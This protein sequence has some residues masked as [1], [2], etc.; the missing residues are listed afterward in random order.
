MSSD[1]P[2]RVF[3]SYSH[4]SPDHA[5]SMLRLADQLR[6]DGV[7]AWIDQYETSPSR[8]WPQWMEEQ[9][10]RADFVLCVC[11]E[12]YRRRFEQ[13]EDPGR[14][15]GVTWEGS[16]LRIRLY[17][18]QGE[19]RKIRPLL[20]DAQDEEHIPLLL[21]P[22]TYFRPLTSSG[23]ESLLRYLTDQPDTAAPPLGQRKSLLTRRRRSL[24]GNTAVPS[25]SPNE[26]VSS[27]DV[28]SL[29]RY[30]AWAEVHYSHLDLIG[31]NAGDVQ[32]KL[33]DVYVPLRVHHRGTL[34]A[35]ALAFSHGLQGAGEG[36][37]ENI[38]IEAILSD[39]HA[40]HALVF[41]EPGAGK[42]TALMKLHQLCWNAPE[43]LGLAPKTLPLFLRLRHLTPAL[44]REGLPAFF[45]HEIDQRTGGRLRGFGER[46][47]QHGRLLLLFDGLDE[48]GDEEHRQEVLRHIAWTVGQPEAAG[49]RAVVSCRRVGL[50]RSDADRDRLFQTYEARPFDNEQIERLVTL[51]FQEMARRDR[52][53]Q[54]GA[55]QRVAKIRTALENRKEGSQQILALVSNPLLL[56]LLCVVV[57][58]GNDIPKR[59]V[60]FYE[61]CLDVLLDRWPQ[62]RG[63]EAP[64]DSESARTALA[65][66]AYFLHSQKRQGDLDW[67]EAV[68]EFKNHFDNLDLAAAFFDWVHEEVGLLADFTATRYGFVHLGI[69]EHLTALHLK[70]KPQ[71]LECLEGAVDPSWWTEVFLQL[72]ALSEREG[73]DHLMA[74][75]LQHTDALEQRA[76]LLRACLQE[77]RHPGLGAFTQVLEND[78]GPRQEAAL[79]LLRGQNHLPPDLLAAVERLSNEGT[80]EVRQAATQFLAVRQ[81]GDPASDTLGLIFH[82]QEDRPLVENLA[83]CLKNRRGGWPSRVMPLA[84][85]ESGK[86][87]STCGALVV[88]LGSN[89][90]DMQRLAPLRRIY[91]QRPWLAVHL[92]GVSRP[93]VPPELGDCD[94]LDWERGREDDLIA[95]LLNH[96]PQTAE[97][98]DTTRA[99]SVISN[100]KTVPSSIPAPGKPFTEETTGEVFLP[101]PG[102]RFMMGSDDLFTPEERETL[103]VG[104]NKELVEEFLKAPTPAHLVQLSPFWMAQTPVTN[105]QYSLFLQSTGREEPP[106]WRDRRFSDPKQPV[107]NVNWED[108]RAYCE[109]LTQQDEQDRVFALP[110]EAQREFAARG[111]EGFLHPWGEKAP[112][113]TLACFARNY[114]GDHPASVGSFSEGAGPYGHLDLAGLV[115]EW[116]RDP[117]E[118]D[119]SRWTSQPPRDPLGEGDPKKRPLRGGCWWE[120]PQGLRSAIRLGFLASYRNDNVGFRVAGS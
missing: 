27:D 5:E 110:T 103:L 116:C 74:R 94:V 10:R 38:E 115:W 12:I 111:P 98:G 18:D 92:P 50:P 86:A 41:G 55:D 3:L 11:T 30:R 79:R 83:D 109:W 101:V 39:N 67:G 2:V 8:G 29:E 57:L 77:T 19:N 40:R 113:R 89:H 58:L 114:Q 15:L 54:G 59:R 78:D 102:G 90:G 73:F 1:R 49:L 118:A 48:I 99:P 46:L 34:K 17:L 81:T 24:F 97:G 112:D 44:L 91:A 104:S 4:D 23:Y 25:P 84:G 62:L 105:H 16:L 42:T 85:R 107:V 82:H 13:E 106:T 36:R 95:A 32:V 117:W 51:W 75:L 56:T 65:R 47:W 21:R 87:M 63:H 70:A 66:L 43:P 93:K 61:Q 6:A 53:S 45:E 20:F 96:L 7:D 108:A 9:V 71:A 119:Y 64:V 31:I 14:G 120:E 88:L 72:S 60:R 37:Q 68:A 26:G 69:Q 33:E 22:F 100:A 80:P 76:G 52:I 35:E 28:L